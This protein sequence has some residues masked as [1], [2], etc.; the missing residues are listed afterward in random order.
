MN[1]IG[2]TRGVERLR[3]AEFVAVATV[4]R[5]YDASVS[6]VSAISTRRVFRIRTIRGKGTLRLLL[7]NIYYPIAGVIVSSVLKCR[8]RR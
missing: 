3:A 4:L 1:K 5:M 2:S 8:R 6:D 7:K